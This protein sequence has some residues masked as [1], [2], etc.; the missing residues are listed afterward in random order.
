M[1][2]PFSI[3]KTKDDINSLLD[4]EN[5]LVFPICENL[6]FVFKK[7]LDPF[8]DVVITFDQN[9]APIAGLFHKQVRYFEHYLDLYKVKN[10]D[11]CFLLHRIIYEAYIKMRYLIDHPEDITEYRQLAYKPHLKILEDEDSQN[12]PVVSVFR[13]KFENS[14]NIEGFSESDI[15]AARKDPGGKNFRQ[16]QEMYEKGLY[17]S[18]YG[19][20]SDTIHSGWNE[21]RQMYLRCKEDEKLY[22]VDVDYSQPL[23]YRLLITIAQILIESSLHYQTWICGIRPGLVPNLT[24]MINEMKRMCSLI[25]EVVIDTYSN[26]PN[27]YLYK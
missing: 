22:C 1:I 11:I 13:T 2:T 16:M 20:T 6:L 9:E 25:E 17:F 27:E 8:D 24:S 5:K 23:H 26:N 3:Y 19:T 4:D 14:L 10:V 12:N 15:R 21:I 7:M 18:M